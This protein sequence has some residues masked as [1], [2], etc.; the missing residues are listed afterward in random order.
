M[1]LAVAE[2]HRILRPGG[3]LLDLHP[4]AEPMRL[5]DWVRLQPGLGEAA[6]DPAGCQRQHLGELALED[7]ASDF[8]AASAALVAAL[9][10]DFQPGQTRAF[11][12]RYFFDSLDELSD[13]LDENEQ[14]PLAS[15]ELLERAL[16]A[17]AR[18][19]APLKLVLPQS[20][21]SLSSPEFK[22]D[23]AAQIQKAFPHAISHMIFSDTA[24][25]WYSRSSSPHP[26]EH[27]CTQFAMYSLRP[28]SSGQ[29]SLPAVFTLFNQI[30]PSADIALNDLVVAL[31]GHQ[32]LC[33]AV[34]EPNG[35]LVIYRWRVSVTP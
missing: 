1:A 25:L 18:A 22:T 8:K 4:A 35:E 15:D 29:T 12:Y 27:L 7:T 11:E 2:A 33:V 19:T 31:P 24:N 26:D 34:E 10:S 17:A 28:A 16:Q 9:Q 32:V 3:W 21:A 13:Y 14:L 23:L 6:F 20:A 5:E 30:S